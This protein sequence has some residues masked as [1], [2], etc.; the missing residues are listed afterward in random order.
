MLFFEFLQVALGQR[1][2]LSHTPTEQEWELLYDMADKQ[3]V[4]GVCFAA[5]E[6]LYG[7]RQVPPQPLL[8]S[9]I[10]A[11]EAIKQRNELLNKQCRKLQ[12]KLKEAGIRSSILKGQAVAKYYG[13]TDSTD[14]TE[15]D[16]EQQSSTDKLA[17]YR[18]P[19]DID[20]Y[21][22]CGSERAMQFAREQGVGVVE[23]DYKHLHLDVFKDTEV[24]VHYRVEV[25]LNLWKNR[26]LQRWFKEHTE[27]IFC[28]TEST[29][30]TEIGG[31]VA[32]S[33]SFNLFYILLHIYR[34]FLYEGVGMRQLMDYFFV[35]RHTDSTDSTEIIKTLKEFGMMRFAQGIMWVMQ[36][37]FALEHQYMIGEPLESEG[38]FILEEVM[39]G[40]NFGQYDQ[41]LGKA[42]GKW[43]AVRRIIRH[44]I[45][46][47]AHY[48]SDVIWAPI[49]IAWH[50][51]WK[52]YQIVKMR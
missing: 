19:G 29:N 24:E 23:W 22:D 36:K 38:R 28:H 16:G 8:F 37:V 32:P 26:K 27:E 40:G 43:R 9:W 52:K 18:Q 20:V 42:G 21:V 1:A 49:W 11:A 48:P 44:N 41:Q 10:G 34:H 13:H 31:L 30:N 17:L 45:H 3:A 33:T 39:R 35:L 15:D 5:I 50:W 47:L 14:D 12:T 46:L 6:R 7:Q 25:M 51:V 4:A 2:C